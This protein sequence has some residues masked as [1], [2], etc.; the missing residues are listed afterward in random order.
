MTIIIEVPDSFR[1]VLVKT[2]TSRIM[3]FVYKLSTGHP[4]PRTTIGQATRSWLV[5]RFAF[6]ASIKS[7]IW[8]TMS[9]SIMLKYDSERPNGTIPEVV[10]QGFQAAILFGVQDAGM[11]GRRSLC[12]GGI[13]D[14][15]YEE[16]ELANKV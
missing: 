10:E 1:P 13:A 15:N 3:M 16:G 9:L 2:T 12:Y 11:T 4:V 14:N 7:C 5:R 8:K 6:H